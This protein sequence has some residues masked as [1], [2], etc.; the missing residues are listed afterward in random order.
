MNILIINHF[1]KL[2]GE[3]FRDQRYTFLYKKLKEKNN[4]T[5]LSSDFHHWTHKNRFIENI[6]KEDRNNIVLIKTLSYQ[7]NISIKRFI[8]HS[9]VS[10]KTFIYLL[11]ERKKYDIMI[12]IA[13]VENL[14]LSVIYSKITKTKLVIDI[15]D[16]WPDLFIQAFPKK[17]TL[18]GRVILYPYHLMANYA[19]KKADHI[20]SVSKTYTK[21]GMSR[22]KRKDY[23]NSS[24]FYLGAPTQCYIYNKNKSKNKLK[25]LFAGQ[26]G[27]NYDIEIILEVA[28]K[29]QDN[30]I[31]IEFNLA[32]SGFK[33][34]YIEEY[35]KINELKNVN[36][37]GWLDSNSLLKVA[38]N[39]HVGLNCYKKF[40]TQSVPT[41]IFDY[42]ALGL[43]IINSLKDEVEEMIENEGIGVT[44]EVENKDDLFNK[45]SI[46]MSNIDRVIENGEFNKNLFERKYTFEEI[47]VNMSNTIL[48]VANA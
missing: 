9:L 22:S 30:K 42:M 36:L 33:L 7:N 34:K 43:Y 24:Y 13:P 1:D 19:Y 40:A 15:L 6:T 12:V 31:D 5:W 11:K 17:L 44:Y 21:I 32:G 26:F 16:L 38:E 37:L 46:L 29:F 41:K 48:G 3:N 28:K 35:I 39:C 25:C 4:V 2:P 14:F 8:S 18:F 27:Y 47:Y 45:L 20:T 23:Q 10:I